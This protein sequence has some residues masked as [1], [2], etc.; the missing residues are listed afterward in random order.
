MKLRNN[1][2]KRTLVELTDEEKM[3]VA[4][5]LLSHYQKYNEISASLPKVEGGYRTHAA[6]EFEDVANRCVELQRALVDIS[7]KKKDEEIVV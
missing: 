1:G 4:D 6:S 5:A 2:E 7:E 3:L